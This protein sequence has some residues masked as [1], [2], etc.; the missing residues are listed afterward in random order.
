MSVHKAN[1]DNGQTF[2]VH[3]FSDVQAVSKLMPYKLARHI[4]HYQTVDGVGLGVHVE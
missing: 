2:H 3:S 1:I 4:T